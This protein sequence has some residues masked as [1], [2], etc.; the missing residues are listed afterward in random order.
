M[1][2]ALEAHAP[3]LNRRRSWTLAADK[4]LFGRWQAVVT[5]GR[6][7]RRGQARRH[8]FEDEAGLSRF[9]RRALLR[10]RSATRRIGVSYEAVEASPS[11]LPLLMQLGLAVRLPSALELGREAQEP[12][13]AV[14][15]VLPIGGVEHAGP[16]ARWVGFPP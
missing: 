1:M 14:P 16:E 3:A 11:V 2:I 8:A 7:G 10:R 4:D 13:A 12:V 5:F 15:R 9:V 6:I